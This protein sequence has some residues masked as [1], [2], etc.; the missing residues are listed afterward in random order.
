MRRHAHTPLVAD[1]GRRL[2]SSFVASAAVVVVVVVVVVLDPL[3][4]DRPKVV[5]TDEEGGPALSISAESRESLTEKGP[6]DI[7]L[8]TPLLAAPAPD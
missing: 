6:G 5:F 1:V 4:S 7:L 3:S 8:G 2:G